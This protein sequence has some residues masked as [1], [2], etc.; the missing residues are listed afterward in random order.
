MDEAAWRQYYG[1]ETPYAGE[2]V[3]GLPE[4]PG[5]REGIAASRQIANP[6]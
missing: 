4:L 1:S 3:Y 6:G 2:W 5:A